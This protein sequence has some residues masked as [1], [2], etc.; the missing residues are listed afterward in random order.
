MKDTIHL[1]PEKWNLQYFP[2]SGGK[3]S[4]KMSFEKDALIFNN[5]E[6][7][8]KQNIYVKIISNQIESF[9]INS[10]VIFNEV[11]ISVNGKQH[12]FKGILIS[13]QKITKLLKDLTKTNIL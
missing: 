6:K 10:G 7:N 3:Y 12:L 13:T 9:T 8:N 2:P 5:K 11:S 4:G 1:Q